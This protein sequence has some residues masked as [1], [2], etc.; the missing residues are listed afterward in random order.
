MRRCFLFILVLFCFA[1]PLQLSADFD[2]WTDVD[3]DRLLDMLVSSMTDRQKLGQL[4]LFGYLGGRPSAEILEWIGE[5]EIG[6]VKLFGWNV[7]SLSEC[8]WSVTKMQ[9]ASQKTSFGIPLFIVT[10]QEGGW[11]RHIHRGTSE[12]SGNLSLG[13]SGLAADSFKS[14]YFIGMELHNLGVNMNFAPTVDVYSNVEA[15]VIGSRAFSDD[16]VVTA[17]LSVA[18]FRGMNESGVICTAKHFPGHG[19]ADKDSHGALPVIMANYATLWNRELLP[20]RFLV[21]EG[22][23]AV[24]SGHLAFPNVTGDNTPASISEFFL[25]DVLRDRIGFE[26]LVVTD[27][28]VMNG[29]QQLPLST[30]EICKRA[31]VA[32]N[33]VI[34]LSRTPDLQKEVWGF[35]LQQ[36]LEDDG[37]RKRV[38]ESCERVL[39]IKIRYLRA[40]NAVP[41]FPD[42]ENIDDLIPGKEASEFFFDQA[43]RSVTVLRSVDGGLQPRG[44]IL[45]AGQY[46]R[47]LDAGKRAFPDADV[48]YFD[49]SPFYF[50]SRAVIDQLKERVRRYDT[51]IFCLS[52]PNSANVLRELE[53]SGTDVIVFSVLTPI[54]ISEMDWIRNA[55]AVYGTSKDAFL[56]GFSVLRGEVAPGG[57]IP[58]KNIF[59][60]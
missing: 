11:V 39:K 40:D 4:M 58:L 54:Y 45:L 59:G 51:V 28:I 49:Y 2:F 56:A 50:S 8:A 29:V 35:L 55:I 21:R 26:G 5:S 38:N 34:L 47:F 15:H 27:D 1:L 7:A 46:D 33:D 43:V 23:P 30:S 10:D 41:L 60:E 6:G 22:L 25:V 3:D 12:T 13:A 48:F 52:N 24:M 42:Y 37:F 36:L 44:K 17:N 31:I 9:E 57:S 20:Y 32:G 19:D 18:Y 16:A 14:G 53:N